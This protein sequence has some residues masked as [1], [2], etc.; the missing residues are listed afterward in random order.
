MKDL[1]FPPLPQYH[2]PLLLGTTLKET[3]KE[4]KKDF[5]NFRTLTLHITPKRWKGKEAENPNDYIISILRM[6]SISLFHPKSS[7]SK[8]WYSEHISFTCPPTNTFRRVVTPSHFTWPAYQDAH[9]SPITYHKI[10]NIIHYN[11]SKYPISKAKVNDEGQSKIIP[12][13][14]C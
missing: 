1:E 2:M 3:V 4:L 12:K 5:Q 6:F 7:S 10:I 11:Q 13:T 9:L 8:K 14:S